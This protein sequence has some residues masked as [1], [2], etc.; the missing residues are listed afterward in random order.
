MVNDLGSQQV[1]VR[2]EFENFNPNLPN[3]DRLPSRGGVR[4]GYVRIN[5][6]F[7]IRKTKALILDRLVISKVKVV[8]ASR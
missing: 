4:Q 1:L 2:R 5:N 3:K 6:A 7:D 8:T